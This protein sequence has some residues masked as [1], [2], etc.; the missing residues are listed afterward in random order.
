MLALTGTAWGQ[1]ALDDAGKPQRTTETTAAPDTSDVK[2]PGVEYGVDIR[3]R[4]VFV[5][6]GVIELFVERAADGASNNGIG[7][8][9]VRRRGNVELQLG[10]EYEHI[11]PGEGAWINSGDNV[12]AGDEADYIISADHAGKSFGWFTLE[13]TFINHAPINKYVAVRYG[14]GAGIGFLTGELQKYDVACI[15]ATNENPEP[16]CRPTALG[17]TGIDANNAPEAYDMPPVF[18]VVNAIVGLQ[19]RPSPKAVVNIEGGI[20]TIPFI[21]MS[22]GYFF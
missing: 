4:R 2:E 10:F 6:K 16:G 13:F 19:I 15:G 5:P 11:E 12:A 9:L 3:L 8:D 20:R 18:P 22:A 21:G 7:V 14:G 1:A 17:G